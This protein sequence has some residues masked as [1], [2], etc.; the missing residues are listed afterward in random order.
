MNVTPRPRYVALRP[1]PSHCEDTHYVVRCQSSR[2]TLL[3]LAFIAWPPM[4]MAN[5]ARRLTMWMPTLGSLALVYVALD[6]CGRGV[7]AP[8]AR[9]RTEA[10]MGQLSRAPVLAPPRWHG[11]RAVSSP[12]YGLRLGLGGRARVLVYRCCKMRVC[13]CVC[14]S[15][16]ASVAFVCVHDWCASV[17]D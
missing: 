5:S 3:N 14:F 13:S 16:W 11:R 7:D 15:V 4:P 12:A 9:T 2:T 10:H 1:R 17:T 6:H 8:F